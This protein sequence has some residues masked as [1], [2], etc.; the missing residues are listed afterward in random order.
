MIVNEGPLLAQSGNSLVRCSITWIS[1]RPLLADADGVRSMSG[2]FAPSLRP[3]D[4]VGGTS[5]L[6]DSPL[7]GGTE[8]PIKAGQR[9]LDQ[10][11]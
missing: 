10:P 9:G 3:F 6:H 11:P 4:L 7:I 1:E 8:S 5:G 2:V